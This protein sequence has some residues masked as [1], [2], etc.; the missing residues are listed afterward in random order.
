ML[1]QTAQSRDVTHECSA[2]HDRNKKALPKSFDYEPKFTDADFPTSDALY[3]ADY[4]SESSGPIASYVDR[5]VWKRASDEY[6]DY[7]FW[8]E[9]GISPKD[10]IQG[11]I[12]NCWFLAIASALAEKPQRLEKIFINRGNDLN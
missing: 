12:G 5:I 10:V 4:A 7:P 1:A 2:A 11:A 9:D 3:W 8:G 6:A